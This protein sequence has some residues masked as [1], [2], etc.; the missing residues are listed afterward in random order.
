MK[1]AI[2]Y[3]RVSTERQGKSGLGLDAQQNAVHDFV[4]SHQI[5]LLDEFIEIESGKKNN[6]PMLQQALIACKQQ[7]AILLIAR[8]DRL[9]RN[10]AFVSALMESGVEFKAVD[11]PQAG[12]LI[13]HILAAF[14]E[15]ERDQIS[16]RTIAA[17]K[18]A[19]ERGVELGSYGRH[20]L[21][22]E[23]KANAEQFA[24][25]MQPLIERLR[26]RGITTVRAIMNEL[27]R[28]QVPTYRN[29]GKWHLS[30]VYHLIRRIALTNT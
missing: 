2:T 18:A 21:S 23:N 9:A 10:V 26:E 12:K 11:N 3:Y 5:F 25:K 7:N 1:K 16:E 22:K 4:R 28:L 24:R 13:V 15:H 30:T 29:T 19:K 27:N 6:R 8:L 20:V 14:A 17:L